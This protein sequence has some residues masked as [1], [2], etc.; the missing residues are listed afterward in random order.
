MANKKSVVLVFCDVDR[1]GAGCACGSCNAN[2]R[3]FG[4]AAFD[5]DS[6][7]QNGGDHHACEAEFVE[8]AASVDSAKINARLHARSMGQRVVE[9]DA[10]S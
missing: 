2:G 10:R 1:H 9:L 7:R 4:C 6:V 8:Y 5:V 3:S